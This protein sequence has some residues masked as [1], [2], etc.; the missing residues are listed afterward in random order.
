MGKRRTYT[1]KDYS[2]EALGHEGSHVVYQYLIA[3]QALCQTQVSM[4][5][6]RSGAS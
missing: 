4:Q 3:Y 2:R 5:V 1:S 6:G